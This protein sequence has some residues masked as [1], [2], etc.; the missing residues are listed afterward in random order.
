[1]IF[2]E[3]STSLN[4]V[5]TVGSQIAETVR[6]HRPIDRSGA[7]D[8]AIEMMG[9]V[10]IPDPEA[11]Y[12]SYPHQLSG[13]LKQ[14]VMIAI[15]LSCDPRILIADEPTTALDVTIQAQIIELLSSL[16]QRL[17]LAV[18]LISHDL[19]LVAGIAH[20]VA[21]MYAGRIIEEAAVTELF[22]R[23]QHPYTVGLL[24][25]APR[26]DRDQPALAAIPGSV[27]PAFA[28]PAG[29]RFHPRC[30]HAWDRCT[31]EEPDVLQ[32]GSAHTSRCWLVTEPARRKSAVTAGW[33]VP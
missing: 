13:G 23:P 6:A 9:L 4:P 12:R 24:Q 16:Q 5:L 7:R 29:C 21:V 27:P 31:R 11:R 32:T 19:G 26:V 22:A 20:R 18:L 17:G 10:G 25:A 8:R 15:A 2:Q 30:A 14:R 1:M 3:P 28:W 33:P